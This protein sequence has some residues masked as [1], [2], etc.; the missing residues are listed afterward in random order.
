MLKNIENNRKTKHNQKN[1]ITLSAVNLFYFFR[2]FE[3]LIRWKGTN[4]LYCWKKMCFSRLLKLGCELKFISPWRNLCQHL[5][6]ILIM[7]LRMNGLK[8]INPGWKNTR[9][10]ITLLQ[11]PIIGLSALILPIYCAPLTFAG[12]SFALLIFAQIDNLYI[13]APIIFAHW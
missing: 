3:W 4:I 7:I 6:V 10:A 9:V 11:I 8:K 13:G 5:A 12:F 2:S 1:D